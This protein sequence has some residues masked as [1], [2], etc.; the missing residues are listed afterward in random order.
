MP[1]KPL[2]S[3]RETLI[4]RGVENLREFGYGHATK[5]NILTD[6]VYWAFFKSMLEACPIKEA[7]DLL[8]ETAAALTAKKEG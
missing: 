3:I 2:K 5:E 7:K 4:E 8:I 1:R 6:E